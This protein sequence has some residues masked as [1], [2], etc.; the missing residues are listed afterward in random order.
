MGTVPIAATRKMSMD[1][2][3]VLEVT[4]GS[5]NL[6]VF[7]GALHH[8]FISGLVRTI[9]LQ[10]LKIW[11]ISSK[12]T[13]QVSVEDANGCIIST[14]VTI[15]EQVVLSEDETCPLVIPNVFTPNADGV[16]DYFEIS[17]LYNYANAQIEIFNRNGNLLYKKDHYG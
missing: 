1:G 11:P 12:G 4:G 3:T 5:I 15:D 8:L 13:Y 6:T 2:T 7:R 14:S 16:H 10:A 17:C 9:L